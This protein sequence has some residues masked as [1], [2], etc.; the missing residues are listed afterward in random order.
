MHKVILEKSNEI[1]KGAKFTKLLK[2]STKQPLFLIM[3]NSEFDLYGSYTTNDYFIN[4]S[5]TWAK[6]V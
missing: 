6:L 5:N 3:S 1:V 4:Y 2:S